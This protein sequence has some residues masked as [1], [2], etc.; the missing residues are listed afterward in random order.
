MSDKT[1]WNFK[2][3]PKDIFDTVLDLQSKLKKAKSKKTS[4]EQICYALIRRGAGMQ[5]DKNQ[6]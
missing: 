6:E 1:Q 3:V 4:I 2:N 5:A